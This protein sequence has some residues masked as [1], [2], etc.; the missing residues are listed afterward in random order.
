MYKLLWLAIWPYT[1][2]LA[3]FRKKY[4]HVCVS[5]DITNLDFVSPSSLWGHQA[6]IQHPIWW[7]DYVI[8]ADQ[9]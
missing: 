8:M 1:K 7:I 6:T 5:M 9:V 3:I 2:I 4:P